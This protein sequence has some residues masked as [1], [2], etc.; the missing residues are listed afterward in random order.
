MT[1]RS[2]R[3]LRQ[4]FGP[5]TPPYAPD[6]P[7]P[8][9]VRR[10][11]LGALCAQRALPAWEREFP[12]D[13]RPHELIEAARHAARTPGDTSAD[14]DALY[15]SLELDVEALSTPPGR[16]LAA[17]AAGL[18]ALQLLIEARDGDLD[19]DFHAEDESDED[20]DDPRVEV[21]GAWAVAGDDLDAEREYWR[22]YVTEAFPA[23]Y[24]AVPDDWTPT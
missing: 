6:G 4:A 2:R 9:Q 16:G 5:W 23:A 3:G 19:P 1:L 13:R 20:L 12:H 15:R 18:A 14:V 10:A 17:F 22:W 21:L 24:S 7:D 8:G 11:E